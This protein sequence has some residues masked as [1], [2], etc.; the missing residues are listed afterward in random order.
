[1]EE[2]LFLVE[3]SDLRIYGMCGVLGVSGSDFNRQSVPTERTL[4]PLEESTKDLWVSVR[5][6][7]LQNV[8]WL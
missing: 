1:M 7:F 4:G 5:S 2:Q 6:G 3:L 8:L